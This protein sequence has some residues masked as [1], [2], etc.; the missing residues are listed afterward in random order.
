MLIG[1]SW[2]DIRSVRV[3]CGVPSINARDHVPV[4]TRR[5]EGGLGGQPVVVQAMKEAIMD[6]EG[7][8]ALISQGRMFVWSAK[9]H[10]DLFVIQDFDSCFRDVP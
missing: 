4:V 10:I 5:I 6:K 1:R 8:C 9:A 2:I 3:E 7:H